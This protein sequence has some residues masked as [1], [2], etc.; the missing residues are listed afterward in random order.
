[1]SCRNGAFRYNILFRLNNLTHWQYSACFQ[2]AVVTLSHRDFFAT[3]TASPSTSLKKIPWRP[4]TLP[5]SIGTLLQ[6]T[7]KT[8]ISRYLEI[9][10]N[11]PILTESW[12][13]FNVIINGNFQRSFLIL[14][15]RIQ[16]FF[17]DKDFQSWLSKLQSQQVLLRKSNFKFH[18]WRLICFSQVFIVRYYF[19]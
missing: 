6:S 10:V 12:L 8:W 11:Q 4:S 18:R 5:S 19:R 1:M 16:F 14:R 13:L 3:S 15:H 9:K 2:A 7:H 17:P